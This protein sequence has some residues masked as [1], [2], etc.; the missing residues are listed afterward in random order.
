[1][2]NN[3]FTK[4]ILG[5]ALIA[6][7]LL[8]IIWQRQNNTAIMDK[9]ENMNRNYIALT[10]SIRVI[11][12]PDGNVY[13]K[14]SVEGTPQDII[15]SVYFSQLYSDQQAFFKEIAKVKGLL[16]ATQAQLHKQDSMLGE[17]SYGPDADVSDSMVCLPI[18]YTE[19]IGDTSKMLK[20]SLDLQYLDSMKYT[21]RYT[22]D[23]II[24]MS[25]KRE[26]DKSINVNVSLNDPNVS[27]SSINSLYIPAEKPK[28]KFGQWYKRHEGAFKYIGGTILVSGGFL[29]GYYLR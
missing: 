11:K 23:P 4:T 13:Q 20:W 14:K 22:Y 21:F 10:D 16:A 9:L 18:G 7:L 15:N 19:S 6:F 28:T 8:I 24:K 5:I 3:G 25:Y 26:K 29:A 17:M 12:T 27:V 2:F 1:M